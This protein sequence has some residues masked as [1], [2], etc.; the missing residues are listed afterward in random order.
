LRGAANFLGIEPRY[1]QK[2]CR[3]RKIAHSR[4]HRT[5]WQFSKQALEDFL[6]RQTVDVR[7]AKIL[8]RQLSRRVP[9]TP[10]IEK[11]DDN[12]ALRKELRALCRQ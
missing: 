11:I 4:L 1:L 2:L 9:S 6:Q 7:P 12:L 3:E 8:D 10:G 5:A